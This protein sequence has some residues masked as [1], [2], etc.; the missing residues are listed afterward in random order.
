MLLYLL[1]YNNYYNRVVKRE[2]SLSQYLRYQV[3]FHSGIES[4]IQDQNGNSAVIEDVNFIE[5]DFVNTTQVV[6]WGGE[7]PDYVVVVD[8]DQIKSRWFVVEVLKTRMGQLQLTLHR[9]LVVDFYEEAVTSPMF[10]EK[11][12]IPY[13]GATES[14][15][16][17]NHED[18]DFNQI[19]IREEPL[20]DDTRCPWVVVYAMRDASTTD[21]ATGAATVNPINYEGS[22]PYVNPSQYAD[23]VI[24]ISTPEGAADYSILNGGSVSYI[25]NLKRLL[26]YGRLVEGSIPYVYAHE[27][28]TDDYS[29]AQVQS[30][31]AGT[32]FKMFSASTQAG[33]FY[34]YTANDIRAA[35]GDMDWNFIRTAL[36][37]AY[38]LLQNPTRVDLAPYNSRSIKVVNG[39]TLIGYYKV[40]V[41][42]EEYENTVTIMNTSGYATIYSSINTP[43]NNKKVYKD[44]N[45]N[46]KTLQYALVS[47]IKTY[48]FNLT[49]L[50]TE[51]YYY[52]IA[53]GN[54]RVHTEDAPY[55]IWCMPYSDDLKVRVLQGT[56]YKEVTAKKYIATSFATSLMLKYGQQG[57]WALD[58][59]LLP[60]CPFQSYTMSEGTF[61]VDAPGMYWTPI[62]TS[63]SSS[64]ETVGFIFHVERSSFTVQ[65]IYLPEPI[66]I[67]EPKVQS[68]CDKYRLV[69]P[70]F[71]GMFDIN[72]VMNDGLYQFNASCTYKPYNPYVKVYP[73]FKGLYGIN[74]NDARGCILGGDFSL[75]QASDAWAS[76]QLN[77]KNYQ[78]IFNREVEHLNVEYKYQRIQ[79]GVQVAAGALQG[80]VSGAGAG[81]AGGPAGM[82]A[83]AV[84]GTGLSIGGGI[85][86]LS[87]QKKLFRENLDYKNDL[88]GYQL[89]NIKALSQSLAKTSALNEDN[90]LVPFLEYYTCTET[91]KEALRNKIKYNGMTVM[92]IGT[93]IE[94]IR[95][96]RSYIKGKLIRCEDF[97]GSL[98]IINALADEL[99]QGVF[100]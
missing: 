98:N 78:S 57:K 85:A 59:Q 18:M 13:L 83:G 35:M 76:Y 44:G 37:S 32:E 9:D 11:A 52:N 4:F 19:K 60:Y 36:N 99:N 21:D 66:T 79:S 92:V 33:Q 26:T 6:N 96:E 75:P 24:D 58:I 68:E 56:T 71:N 94:Y 20:Y 65:D 89:G 25:N 38:N 10:I 34:T 40:K 54:N 77:N 12:T 23:Y 82:I 15:L 47:S 31:P 3:R 81:S 61:T 42:S 74:Q 63:S 46:A 97:P 8:E 27:I 100:I 70:N 86:D 93:M 95:S 30:Y 16:I 1:K 39:S 14:P 62:T 41:T 51:T 45:V 53:S 87:I 72:A 48:N 49:Q 5:G 28:D 17:F 43:M 67:T 69:S 91:E 73:V 90:R 50:P 2:E 29:S 80:G 84:L 7:L 55:D 22:L 64:S 88:F